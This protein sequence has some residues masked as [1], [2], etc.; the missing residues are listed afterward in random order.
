MD[1][2]GVL[3]DHF[4]LLKQDMVIKL[5]FALLAQLRLHT[6]V[7]R[8]TK[9]SKEAAGEIPPRWTR[10]EICIPCQNKN[11]TN[12]APATPKDPLPVSTADEPVFSTCWGMIPGSLPPSEVV[13]SVSVEWTLED[14]WVVIVG[15]VTRTV[16][17]E[18]TAITEVV[19]KI[20][21]DEK[22]EG[23]VVDNVGVVVVVDSVLA[24]L[25]F[26]TSLRKA[27]N[28]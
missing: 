2:I 19:G 10:K 3:I 24:V 18:A 8:K 13:S 4:W 26:F 11:H 14:F 5:G 27:R 15:W 20:S 23:A 6:P 25:Y 28:Q 16:L 9:Y 21:A 1:H 22:L 12:N 17:V 7:Q